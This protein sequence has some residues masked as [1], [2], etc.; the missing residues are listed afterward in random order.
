M[1]DWSPHFFVRQPTAGALRALLDG[2]AKPSTRD[3]CGA[4]GLHLASASGHFG[5]VRVLLG[6]GT[7][8]DITNPRGE[9]AL[10]VA[11]VFGHCDIIRALLHKAVARDHEG[12]VRALLAA[13]A[14]PLI[15][16]SHNFV[17]LRIAAA[18]DLQSITILLLDAGSGIDNVGGSR[19]A[20]G[21]AC[22]NS[23]ASVA[24]LLLD[25]GADLFL[26]DTVKLIRERIDEWKKGKV[27]AAQPFERVLDVVKERY[28]DRYLE[29]WLEHAD[30]DQRRA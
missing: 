17:P 27:P 11:S 29:C 21:W 23:R 19:T 24:L 14:D 16:D 5:V 22:N 6:A 4:T 18:R 15:G 10:H 9:A 7:D 20:L 3:S 28:P 8:P 26:G 13:G 12:I 25:R 2:G 30:R 1:K